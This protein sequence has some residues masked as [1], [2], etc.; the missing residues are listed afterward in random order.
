MPSKIEQ[1]ELFAEF[2]CYH[3]GALCSASYCSE[4]CLE[5]DFPIRYENKKDT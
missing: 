1:M 4:E 5:K 2:E 3:C